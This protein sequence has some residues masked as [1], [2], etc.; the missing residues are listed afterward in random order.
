MILGRVAKTTYQAAPLAVIVQLLGAL[1][2]AVLPIVTAYF[3]AQTTTAL[4][5]AYAGSESAGGQAIEYVIITAL[6]GV[7]AVGWSSVQ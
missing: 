7:L 5:A 3:A 4:A 2:D 6:L 1:V